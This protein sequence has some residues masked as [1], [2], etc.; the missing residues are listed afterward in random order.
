M[1]KHSRIIGVATALVGGA[2]IA[3]AVRSAVGAG[4]LDSW[5]AWIITVG[6]LLIAIGVLMFAS[7]LSRSGSSA[8]L[9][10]DCFLPALR[11]ERKDGSGTGYGRWFAVA[12][13]RLP[14]ALF[15]D[16]Q[17]KHRGLVRR[18]LRWLGI[19]WLSAPIRRLT[20]AFCFLAFL[21]LFFFVC[22]PY[23]ARPR[24]AAEVS[25]GWRFVEFG[26]SEAQ[27]TFEGADVP[28]WMKRGGVAYALEKTSNGR[29]SDDQ[30]EPLP[31]RVEAVADQRVHLLSERELGDAAIDRLLLGATKWQFASRDPT[32]WPSH[33]ADNLERKQWLPAELFLVMD[34]LVSL[35]TAIASR[36]WVWSLACAVIILG[37]EK[38]SGTVLAFSV[39]SVIV[40]VCEVH[41]SVTVIAA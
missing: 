30:G 14:A 3:A 29:A 7:S 32:A 2:V 6:G 1:T 24:A 26:Q 39:S 8:L 28:S 13:K 40:R 22:W 10:L 25:G 18:G 5:L 23:D 9:R 27:L 34:P 12:Q 15:S 21:V 38:V 19:T 37:M 31:L 17:T 36:S 11:R 16:R 4:G 20:Q 41:C 35:S 33:Y